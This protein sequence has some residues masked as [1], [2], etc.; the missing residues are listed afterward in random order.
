M[1]KK[2]IVIALGRNAFGETFPEQQKNVKK[3]AEAIADLV[4]LYLS[5]EGFAV[6]KFYNA[7]DALA[8]VAST[9]L[10]GPISGT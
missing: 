1:D 3:A 8:C 7:L 5:N 10:G 4:E 2:R 9:P 6:H